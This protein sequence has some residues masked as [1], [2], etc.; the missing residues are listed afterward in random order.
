MSTEQFPPAKPSKPV[1]EQNWWML[2]GVAGQIGYIIAIPAVVFA[3][4][5]AYLD[6]YAGTSPLFV[7][8]GLSLAFLVSAFGVGRVIRRLLNP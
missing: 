1:P 2:V 8:L 7:V 6:K 4:G 5:G 3:F